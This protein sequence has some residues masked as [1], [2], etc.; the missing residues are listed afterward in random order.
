M[1]IGNFYE[2][3]Y[4]YRIKWLLQHALCNL[5]VFHAAVSVKC[6]N[7]EL[8]HNIFK[9]WPQLYGTLLFNFQ[10]AWWHYCFGLVYECSYFIPMRFLGLFFLDSMSQWIPGTSL[11][12]NEITTVK[13]NWKILPKSFYIYYMEWN[14]GRAG[15]ND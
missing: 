14:N 2:R 10:V 6:G 1:A 4:W 13:T 11:L 5:F 12:L 3:I 9:R 15:E 7:F 8:L